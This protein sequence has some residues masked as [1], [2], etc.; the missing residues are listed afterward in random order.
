MPTSHTQCYVVCEVEIVSCQEL[1]TKGLLG[2]PITDHCS[3]STYMLETCQHHTAMR[4]CLSD[5]A[6]VNILPTHSHHRAAH[7]PHTESQSF[8]QC[9]LYVKTLRGESDIEKPGGQRTLLP[10]CPLV[11]AQSFEPHSPKT[12]G[13][14]PKVLCTDQPEYL[15]LPGIKTWDHSF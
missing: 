15:L 8:D 7:A 13:P 5:T 4:S 10:V 14:V 6:C 1:K 11:L 9:A 3:L 2:T 12:L